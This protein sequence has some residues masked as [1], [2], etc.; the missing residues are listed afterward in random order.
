MFP[1]LQSLSRVF[2]PPHFL[3]APAAG[4]AISAHALRFASFDGSGE[5]HLRLA[6]YGEAE[7]PDGVFAGGEIKD[8]GAL[9]AI[10]S[11][12][13]KKHGLRSVY[14]SV[15][16]QPSFILYL[17]LPPL[18]R[19]EIRGNLLGR[20]EQHVPFSANDIVFDYEIAECAETENDSALCVGV[21]ILPQKIAADYLLL[22]AECGV[23]PLSLE[24]GAH[25]L[26]RALLPPKNKGAYMLVDI[27]AAETGIAIVHDDIVRFTATITIGG[28]MLSDV[29]AKQLSIPPEEA[30]RVKRLVGLKKTKDGLDVADILIPPLSTLRDEIK[31]YFL[32]WHTHTVSAEAAVLPRIQKI[33]LCGEEADIPGLADY[34]RGSLKESVG[35]ANPW[36]NINSLSAYT[37][38]LSRVHSLRYATAFGLALRAF[39]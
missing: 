20:I 21:T 25:A 35:I 7:I 3:V 30:V 27:D 39:Y 29:L 24:L 6:N 37:P 10:L 5:R 36:R 13:Q 33:I 14:V 11:D 18:Q 38:R 16:E 19:S 22:L 32:Y 8:R 4:L 9:K 17:A 23:E 2:P 26:S 28:N 12:F 1:S 31:R 15:P 34:L